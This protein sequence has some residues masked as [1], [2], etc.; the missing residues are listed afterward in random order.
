MGLL[1]ASAIISGAVKLGGTLI[2]GA[3]NEDKQIKEINQQKTDLTTN[4][5]QSKL[6]LDTQYKQTK[7]DINYNI[8][9]TSK[10]RSQNAN[11]ASQG[12]VK[13]NQFMYEDLSMM[14]EEVV[15]S[16]GQAVQNA[17]MTGF[18]NTEG[19]TQQKAL[20]EVE[21]AK[22]YQ[23]ERAVETVNLNAA[24]SFAAASENYFNATAQLEQYRTNL[25]NLEA[26]YKNASASLLNQ[27]N[28]N[29]AELDRA[30]AEADYTFLEVMLDI[31][32]IGVAAFGDYAQAYDSEQIT[33]L[34][35]EYT[36]LQMNQYRKQSSKSK[37]II[38]KNSS[39]PIMEVM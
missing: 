6:E 28:Q 11:I 3:V 18:R 34:N 1:L 10:L 32:T 14:L 17:A 15:G 8:G 5:T 20:S 33:K 27:Y 21:E 24:Q 9:Y 38:K 7:N 4:Y 12:N 35:S 16:Q 2:S 31:A 39:D 26:N 25:S 30:I 37:T 29:M 23:I 13:N 19:T 36:N 22:L